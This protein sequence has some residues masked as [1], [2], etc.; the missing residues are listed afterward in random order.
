MT[1][2]WECAAPLR[3]LAL[4]PL[5]RPVY[6]LR[7]CPARAPREWRAR[8]RLRRG[9]R[10]ARAQPR[11][12]LA[13]RSPSASSSSSPGRAARASRASRSTRSTPRA[14]AATS[15][16]S[17]PT[18]G[19]SS[20]SS[21]GRR[22]T[23]CAASRRP[24]P[25]SRRAPRRTR[26]RRSAPSPRS[27]TTSASSTPSVGEQHCPTCGKKV[28]RPGRRRRSRS[29]ILALPEG[30]KLTLIGAARH[31]P[32]GRVQGALRRARGARLRP[33]RASTARCTRSTRSPPL[34]KKKKHDVD[35]VVDRLVVRASR[36]GAAR[37][38]RRAR[39][40]RG[41]GRARDA[42]APTAEGTTT[43]SAGARVLRDV[44]PRALAAE[45]LLQLAARHVPGVQR[46][47]A[48]RGRRPRSSSSPTRA[49]PSAAAPSPRGRPAM[50][51]GEGWTARIVDGV[52][53]AFKVDLDTPW[54]KIPKAKQQLVLYGMPRARNR[55]PLGQGGEPEPAAR[56]RMRYEGVIPNLA[57]K[58]P[59][60]RLGHDA[61]PLPPLPPASGPATRAAGERLRHESLAVRL[62]KQEHRRRHRG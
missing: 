38:G 15:R 40:P 32:Q 9:H 18:R 62:A 30:T 16:R 14:S 19:S 31:P 28:A 2:S 41:Q 51:R 55:R 17:A 20:G 37:R 33:R 13:S 12:R 3:P 34:D 54:K 6:L 58:L 60:D 10:R 46:A 36:A 1:R 59:R 24:S 57:R 11:R 23:T 22:S 25:S 8:A 5:G 56:G 27:T 35:L 7:A 47:R 39:A 49:S 42:S 43:F 21:T 26:A 4:G 61:R 45:L 52:A 29:E 50:A 44:V 48:A 53:R